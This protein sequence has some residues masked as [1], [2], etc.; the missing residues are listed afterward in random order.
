MLILL[1]GRYYFGDSANALRQ[2]TS[3]RN[4][5]NK[6]THTIMSCDYIPRKSKRL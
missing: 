6:E 1:N 4:F 3:D 2:W 5:G